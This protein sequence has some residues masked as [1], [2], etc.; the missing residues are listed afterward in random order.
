MPLLATRGAASAKGFGFTAG[1]SNPKYNY[2]GINISFAITTYGGSSIATL[3][4]LPT[5]APGYK[6]SI[7]TGIVTDVSFIV[8][9]GGAYSTNGGKSWTS[10]SIGGEQG[11]TAPS[12]LNG[13]IAY[14]PTA[15]LA[16]TYY[17]EKD[18]KSQTFTFT[19]AGVSS[20]GTT[21]GASMGNVGT[22]SSTG[23]IVYSPTLNYF[24]VMNYGTGNNSG[25]VF[26]MSGTNLATNATLSGFATAGY[27]AGVSNDGYLIQVVSTGGNSRVRKYTATN[28]STYTDYGVI[29]DPYQSYG[30]KSGIFWATVNSKYY[31][32]SSDFTI[33]KNVIRVC[34]ATSAAPQT[35]TLV[36]SVTVNT[37][38]GGSV[39]KIGNIF[40]DTNGTLYVSGYAA[41]YYKGKFSNIGAFT[42]YSTDAGVTWTE[43]TGVALQV[44]SKN[45]T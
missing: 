35:Y 27:F 18:Q 43:K 7:S 16:V 42:Y 33:N 11:D 20:T 26:S 29:S 21:S 39:N 1:V 9:T 38:T 2:V 23:G 15:K 31:I 5:Q 40:E 44:I 22:T 32:A 8:F 34:T 13:G 25:S 6:A 19:V 3:A 4:S 10:W 30:R 12:G 37:G 17:A 14:N 36:G 45:F 28:L 41:Y 24:Y